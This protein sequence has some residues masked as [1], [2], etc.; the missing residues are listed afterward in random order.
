MSQMHERIRQLRRELGMTQAAFGSR[1]GVKGNTVTNYE[2]GLRT[3]SEA[4]LVSL[5]REFRVSPEWLRSGEGEMFLPVSRDEE[6][7][8]FVGAVLAGETDSFQ[9]RF[10]AMLSR[11]DEEQWALL[12]RMVEALQ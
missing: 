5:C 4:V 7:A 10:L 9:R 11:L 8:A 6:I 3:P 1:I 2:T 12:A